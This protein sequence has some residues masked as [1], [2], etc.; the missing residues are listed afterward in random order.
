M[1]YLIV[2][3]ILMIGLALLVVEFYQFVPIMDTN[4]VPQMGTSIGLEN[5]LFLRTCS[6]P[7]IHYPQY[8]SIKH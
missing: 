3:I 6:K 4:N 7:T 8:P 1:P 5:V 2:M